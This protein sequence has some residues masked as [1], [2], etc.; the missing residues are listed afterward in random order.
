MGRHDLDLGYGNGEA[1]SVRWPDTGG[2]S[3]LAFSPDGKWLVSGSE[4]HTA[5]LWDVE[6]GRFVLILPGHVGDVTSVAFLNFKGQQGLVTA[7]ATGVIR[8]W[9]SA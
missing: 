3:A 8:L 4:D 7:D 9:D 1:L 2:V 5:R 6:R